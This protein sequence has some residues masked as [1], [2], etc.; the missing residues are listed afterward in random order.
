[1]V[2]NF[3]DNVIDIVLWVHV[4]LA[5]FDLKV[6][7]MIVGFIQV[8]VGIT[9]GNFIV[10]LLPKYNPRFIGPTPWYVFDCVTAA[11]KK[12]HWSSERHH[13]LDTFCVSLDRHVKVAELVFGKGVSPTLDH[14]RIWSVWIHDHWHHLFEKLIVGDIVHAT[15]ERDIDGEVLPDSFAYLF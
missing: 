3:F 11:S 15:L 7:I 2:C 6:Q 1:M 10:N 13:I 5:R 12:Y 14:K 9:L 8:E 4:L